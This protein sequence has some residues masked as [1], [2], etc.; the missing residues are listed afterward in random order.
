MTPQATTG[1]TRPFSL[2]RYTMTAV[3]FVVTLL[4]SL[5]LASQASALSALNQTAEF[6]SDGTAGSTFDRLHFLDVNQENELLYVLEDQGDSA[7]GFSLIHGYDVSSPGVFDPISGNFPLEGPPSFEAAISVDNTNLPS[8]GNI[9]Y[10]SNYSSVQSSKGIAFG[11]DSSGN[12]FGGNFPVQLPPG[13]GGGFRGVT[14]G[15]AG[16][17]WLA[18]LP[19][20]NFPISS[21][22]KYSSS[23]VFQETIS[24]A[25]QGEVGN[26]MAFDSNGDLYAVSFPQRFDQGSSLWK[27]TAASGYSSSSE[28]I[29]ASSEVWDVAVDANRY[30]YVVK[31]HN[32]TILDPSG[33]PVYTFASDPS[34]EYRAIA[35]DETSGDV[36]LTD[37]SSERVRVFSPSGPLALLTVDAASEI[38]A[39]HATLSGSVNPEGTTITECSFE[40]GTTDSYG[41]TAPCEGAIPADTSPHAVSATLSGLLSQGVTYHYR[42]VIKNAGG[43]VVSDDN[44]FVSGE[45]ATTAAPSALTDSSVTLNG[46]AKP[47]GSTLSDCQFEYGTTPLYGA[48]KPCTPAAGSIPADENEHPVSATLSGLVAQ[49]TYHYR[50]VI[51]N[52][53]GS[54]AGKDEAFAVLGPPLVTEEEAAPVGESTATLLAQV[55]PRSSAT[56]YHFEWGTDSSY[57]NRVPAEGEISA[58]SGSSA[59]AASTDLSGLSGGTTYHFRVVATNASGTTN[60]PDQIF[61]TFRPNSS[62]PNAVIRA[63]Q[64]S[65]AFPEGTIHLPDCMALEKIS[66]QRKFNQRSGE[67]RFSPSGDRVQFFGEGALVGTPSLNFVG[68]SYMSTRGP[69]GWTPQYI[70]P[71]AEYSAGYV[72]G[73]EPCAYTPDFSHWTTWFSTDLQSQLGITTP[74]RA[75]LGGD[76]SPIGPSVQ[77]LS[78]GIQGNSGTIGA[79]KQGACEGSSADA[80]RLFFNIWDAAYLP[81]DPQPVTNGDSRSGAGNVYEAY[82]DDE[83]TPSLRLLQRDRDGNVVGGRCGAR[84]GGGENNLPR[85]RGS[86]STDASRVYFTTRPSQPEGP[87]CDDSANKR[88]IMAWQDTPTGPTIAPL[89]SSECTRVS[90]PCSSA[91]GDDEYQGASQE[92]T[93]VYFSTTRQLTNSDLDTTTDLYLYDA[94]QPEGQRLTQVSAG[95]A[96]NPTP[97]KDSGYLGL[98]DFSGDGSRAYFVAKGVMTTAVNRAGQQAQLNKPNLYLYERDAAHPSAT[99]SYIATLSTGDTPTWAEAPG[100]QNEAKAVPR[101]GADV[102]DL[103]VGGD[104][105]ILVFATRA[106]LATDDEDGGELDIYR[107]DSLTGLLQWVSRAIAGGAGNA[108]SPV[109]LRSGGEE[110]AGAQGVSINRMVSE[111]GRT[112]VFASDQSLD[113]NDDDGKSST[114][115]WRDGSVTGIPTTITPSSFPGSVSMSGDEVGIT[116]AAKLLPEDGDAVNDA[117]ILRAGGGFPIIVPPAPCEG[118]ACQGT[119][120]PRPAELGATSEAPTAGNAKESPPRPCKKGSVRRHGKCVKP[121]AKKKHHKRAK[122]AGHKQG[123]QK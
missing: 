63:A 67:P 102:E 40:Y 66:P 96:T 75:T 26:A 107:Y 15:P 35:I 50:L 11:F 105:R 76:F 77:P 54:F 114:Y 69:S 87:V 64:V 72:T 12:A 36:F 6:G 94:S 49:G 55:D 93:K 65:T 31:P 79:I 52:A 38:R 109:T 78:G 110:A 119:P 104:G 56:G 84:V 85:Y 39:T 8:A 62:C 111:D 71:P 30:V 91:D 1:I 80:T 9:Y 43:P 123:G 45:I 112:I 20:N 34:A 16:S 98:A 108:A 83:G 51:T 120:S 89:F 82:L 116:S 25:A 23:G 24:T 28:V 92:G 117:Y 47:D 121:R 97:D 14:V 81:D 29:P 88:R 118:E 60:G 37:Q 122:R 100:A 68:N 101:L 73:G 41:N 19:N 106:A 5:S 27:Y 21:I 32:V 86:V 61:S 59:V 22:R 18:V 74:F 53:N 10:S 99:T 17:L 70:M 113:P 90:P 103:S 4:A 46:V 115:I 33:K 44:T 42:L 3:S 58:G 13:S 57:G 95:D 2:R 48:S 7:F